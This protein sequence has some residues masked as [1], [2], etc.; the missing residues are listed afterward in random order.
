[1]SRRRVVTIIVSLLLG[2]CIGAAGIVVVALFVRERVE[3]L[4]DIQPCEWHFLVHDANGTPMPDVQLVLLDASNG[5]HW[6]EIGNW[7]GPGSL[8]TDSRGEVVFMLTEG[9]GYGGHVWQIWGYQKHGIPRPQLELR[10]QGYTIFRLPL[11]G[12]VTKGTI[13]IVCDRSAVPGVQG[14]QR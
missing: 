2:A 12:G 10:Y 11:T 6:P 7:R 8:V 9:K 4:A 5:N 3:A 14:D 1:M 13:E